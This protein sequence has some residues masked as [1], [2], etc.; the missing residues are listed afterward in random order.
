MT[1]TSHSD[2]MPGPIAVPVFVPAGRGSIFEGSTRTIPETPTDPTATIQPSERIRR[3]N[4]GSVVHDFYRVAPILSALLLLLGA[5]DTAPGPEDA[6]G[7]PP[8]VSDLTFSPGAVLVDELP[9]EDVSGGKA[10]VQVTAE[11]VAR[12][13]DGDLARVSWVLRGP[14]A[15]SSE[16][17]G[18]DLEAQGAGLYRLEEKVGFPTAIPG[19]YTLLV[20]AYDRSGRLGNDVRGVI[21]VQSVG[22]PPEILG[23]EM[24]ERVVRPADGQPPVPVVL[25]V[26]AS[27]PDGLANILRVEARVDGGAPLNLCDDGGEG[28]CNPILTQASS[29]DAAAGDGRFTVTLQVESS[30]SA[31]PRIFTF[32]AVDRSGLRS[33]VV[34]RTLDIQ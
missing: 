4:R 12:D 34:E 1:A 13:R 11:V 29:G 32:E 2:G 28:A 27:D 31:G 5:C 10:F 30:N 14:Q 18:G 7:I 23:I 25:V 16:I 8:V 19:R 6:G 21:D 15:G 17:A 26:T 3:M 33:E 22:T 9:P 20:F 24:P